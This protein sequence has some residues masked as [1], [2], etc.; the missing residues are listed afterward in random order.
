MLLDKLLQRDAH[1]FF[2]IARIVHVARNAKHLGARIVFASEAGKPG[3]T[4]PQNGRC[5]RD[6]FDVVD[7]RRAAVQAGIRRKRRLDARLA[8][9]AFEAFEKRGF[10]A[11]DIG[12]GT[13]MD[14][15]IEIVARAARVLADQPGRVGL[16]D[17]GIENTRFV[18]EFAAAVDIGRAG[19]HRETGQQTAL[20]QLVRIVTHDLAVLAGTGFGFVGVHD[21]I[22][23]TAGVFLRH[24]RPFEACRETGTATAAQA[25]FFHLVDDPVASLG[26]NIPGPVPVAAGFRALETPVMEAVEVRKD[27]ILVVQHEAYSPVPV[28]VV[29][30]PAGADF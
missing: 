12:S 2:D 3:G 18:M 10:L 25:G 26:E 4:A 23:R 14:V 1:L 6:G 7:R 29:S 20:D 28:K 9:L 13:A 15:N 21:Q 19:A 24:E 22:G 11:A 5:H 17:R 27:T 30:P 16:V 8:L